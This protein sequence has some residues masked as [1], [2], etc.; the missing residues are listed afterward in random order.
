MGL[1][2]YL[3]DEPAKR[4]LCIFGYGE[5]LVLFG[6]QFY[7]QVVF[8]DEPLPEDF[9]ERDYFQGSLWW[10]GRELVDRVAALATSERDLRAWQGIQSWMDGTDQVRII[11]DGMDVELIYNHPDWADQSLPI[12]NP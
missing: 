10:V 8:D 3:V 9:P 5:D 6:G 4:I 1:Y 7:E 11:N 12:I 2:Y